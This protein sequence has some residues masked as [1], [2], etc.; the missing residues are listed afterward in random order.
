MR[1][2]IT[3]LIFSIFLAFFAFVS[4]RLWSATAQEDITAPTMV[5]ARVL[6]P[7][8]T[9]ADDRRI[10]ILPLVIVSDEEG[11]VERVALENGRI[12]G[13]Y[14]PNVLG[15]TGPWAVE[16]VRESGDSMRYGTLDPRQVHVE[17]VEG[18]VPHRSMLETN[19]SYEWVV[20]LNNAEGKDLQVREIRIY[21][22]RENLI[23]A[24]ALRGNEITVLPIDG[25]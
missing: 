23:F 10:A 6:T 12:V 19:I 13:G 9:P 20:P 7:A 21:D 14:G 11:T 17:D 4:L 24:A 3:L 15:L 5:P 8:P 2:S 22:E 1:R 16:L 18:D 25:Q